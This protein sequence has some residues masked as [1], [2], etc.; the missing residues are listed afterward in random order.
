MITSESEKTARKYNKQYLEISNLIC[1]Q[2]D[3]IFAQI[4]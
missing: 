2:T 1:K 3:K 4:V